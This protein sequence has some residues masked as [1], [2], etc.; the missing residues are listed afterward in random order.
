MSED[1]DLPDILNINIQLDNE[2]KIHSI[3]W[4]TQGTIEE[5]KI[6]IRDN[7]WNAPTCVLNIKLYCDGLL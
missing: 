7:V 3:E 2:D 6:Y 5:L 4:S 1:N